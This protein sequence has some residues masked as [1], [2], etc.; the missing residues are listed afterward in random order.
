MAPD[1]KRGA[2]K[3][4]IVFL[5]ESGFMLQPL[6]RRTWAPCA[7]L[8]GLE[9]I[10]FVP[11]GGGDCRQWASRFASLGCREFHLY[12]R[13]IPPESEYRESAVSLVNSRPACR[14]FRTAKRSLENYLHPEAI[15]QAGGGR[16]S[17]DD[18]DCVASNLARHWY[19]LIPQLVPWLE[20]APRARKRFEYRAK[21]W[22]NRHAVEQMTSALL[23][24]RDPDREV[25]HWLKTIAE[26]A[27]FSG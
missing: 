14:G 1:K 22:L 12:D 25:V 7:L 8:E 9:R 5:D 11:T 6:R 10:I 24:E 13:E 26:M 23:T 27:S 15:L 2:R 16:I 19:E 17:I 4:S 21:R 3:A 20:L 18:E